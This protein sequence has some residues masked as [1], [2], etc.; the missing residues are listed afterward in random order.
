VPASTYST[1]GVRPIRHR[2]AGNFTPVLKWPIARTLLAVEANAA[3]RAWVGVA[4]AAVIV[5][6]ALT[7]YLDGGLGPYVVWGGLSLFLLCWVYRGGEIARVA[8]ASLAALGAILYASAVGDADWALASALM[9]GL[10]FVAMLARPVR[11]W[12]GASLRAAD[13]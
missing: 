12:T 6:Q 7:A 2:Q 13:G 10:Q 9:F 1:N 8:V 3:V 5:Q 11:A 4:A